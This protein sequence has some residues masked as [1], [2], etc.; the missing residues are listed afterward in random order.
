M[1]DSY[2]RLGDYETKDNSWQCFGAKD[3]GAVTAPLFI[4]YEFMSFGVQ[5]NVIRES[6]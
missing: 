4:F 6:H 5:S 1:V 2:W 3:Y